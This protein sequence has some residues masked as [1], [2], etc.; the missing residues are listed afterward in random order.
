MQPQKH[1]GSPIKM[2]ALGVGAVG[3][4]ALCAFMLF[5]SNEPLPLRAEVAMW[6]G[7]PSFGLTGLYALRHVALPVP[8]IVLSKDGLYDSASMFPAGLIPWPDIDRVFIYTIQNKKLLGVSLKNPEQFILR[9]GYF[10]R[11][12]ANISVKQGWPLIAIPSVTVKI[13][14]ETLERDI[15]SWLSTS[16]P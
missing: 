9:F 10:R 4:V 3:F 12:F 8:S 7:M 5:G 14:L 13:P 1:F 2:L 16:A 15:N 11:R 6:V